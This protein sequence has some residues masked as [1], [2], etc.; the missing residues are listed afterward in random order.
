M[1]FLS[2]ALEKQA[3]LASFGRLINRAYK[4]NPKRNDPSVRE[5][6]NS[7]F[8]KLKDMGASVSSMAAKHGP[9]AARRLN[10]IQHK[11]L[12]DVSNP[13][14]ELLEQAMRAAGGDKVKAFRLARKGMMGELR[15]M[16]D[17]LIRNA[18]S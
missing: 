4:L 5:V 12:F 1:G 8:T 13:P 10:T 7:F 15:K 6:A 11:S 9:E 17:D 18:G 2:N 3:S 16:T 14:S